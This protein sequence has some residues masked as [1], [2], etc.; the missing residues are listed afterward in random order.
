MST[1][2]AKRSTAKNQHTHQRCEVRRVEGRKRNYA[3]ILETEK[4][5]KGATVTQAKFFLA[6]HQGKDCPNECGRYKRFLDSGQEHLGLSAED[7]RFLETYGP[8][9]ERVKRSDKVIADGNEKE[10]KK[11]RR[12]EREFEEFIEAEA[13]HR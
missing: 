8:D 3:R 5:R 7:K 4:A 11:R 9:G 1:F 6:E 10:N 2:K 13:S 12:E